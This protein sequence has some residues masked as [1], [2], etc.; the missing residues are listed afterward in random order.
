MIIVTGRKPISKVRLKQTK[1]TH[2][3]NLTKGLVLFVGFS[4]AFGPI[5]VSAVNLSDLN[6]QIQQNQEQANALANKADTLANR[7]SEL[8]AQVST[9]SAQ[10]T[11]NQEQSKSFRLIFQQ[12]GM[13][14]L[15]RSK[16]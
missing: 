7:L 14:W 9:L 3:V 4:L 5:S 2:I 15:A 8:N 12:P 1:K 10:I 11:K 6:T 16:C 13:T